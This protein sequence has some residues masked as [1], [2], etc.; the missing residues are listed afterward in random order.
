MTNKEIN[1]EKE[2]SVNINKFRKSLN[3]EPDY[4][5]NSKIET[6][7]NAIIEL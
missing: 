1:I 3:K 2:L 7:K 5:F 6:A 4:L